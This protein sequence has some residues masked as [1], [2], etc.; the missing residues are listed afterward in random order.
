MENGRQARPPD[1]SIEERRFP[2]SRMIR[3]AV[4]ALVL[5]TLVSSAAPALSFAG[6]PVPSH[7]EGLAA[8]WGRVASLFVPG[9][10]AGAPKP[11]ISAKAGSHMDPDGVHAVTIYPGSTTDA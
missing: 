1:A 3:S 6:R 8:A 4:L 10:P 2:M 7:A 9:S 11:G 5:A